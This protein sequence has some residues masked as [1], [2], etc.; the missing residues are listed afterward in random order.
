[1]TARAP[2]IAARVAL[3]GLAALVSCPSLVA[4]SVPPGPR[5]ATVELIETKGSERDEPTAAPFVA[6]TTFGT[7][8]QKQRHLLKQ[9]LEGNS[10]VTP[11]PFDGPAWSGDGSSIAFAGVRKGARGIYV[12]GGDGS[13]PRLVKGTRGGSDPVLSPDGR[14]LA[15]AKSRTHFPRMN[16]KKPLSSLGRYYA[17]TTTW[18]ID[19]G[20]GAARRLSGWR[21]GLYNE[22]ESFSPDGSTLAMTKRDERLDAPR[23]V[24]LSLASGEASEL[25]EPGEDAA[26]SPDGTKLA[27]V[28]YLN[29]IHI[30]AEE[31]RDYMIGELYTANLDGSEPRRLTR[32]ADRIEASPSWNPSG[33]RLAYTEVKADTSFDPGLALLFPTGNAI[34][35]INADGSCRQTVFSSPRVALY[36]VAWQPGRERGSAPLDC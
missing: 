16:P 22:P 24:L 19:L 36:G 28:G 7:S 30:E 31:N 35:A 3:L 32:N 15:F 4:A 23:I 25:P 34:A 20:G 27:F 9:R 12:A 5:L 21:N 29:P 10:E 1:L 8:G 13:D 17:S 33:Q 11:L 18:V 14:M 2:T 26:I 6:L